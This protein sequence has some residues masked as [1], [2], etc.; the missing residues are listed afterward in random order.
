MIEKRLKLIRNSI[1]LSQKDFGAIMG[2]A[3]TSY[4]NYESGRS[5]IPASL[6]ESLAEKLSINLNWLITGEGSMYRDAKTTAGV[7]VTLGREAE[8]TDSRLDPYKLNRDVP[9]KEKDVYLLPV[10]NILLSAG[11]GENWLSN[12][13]YIDKT[14]PVPRKLAS[15]YSDLIAAIVR[16][17]SM[18]PTIK[19][20][21]P[22]A[23]AKEVKFEGD[24]IYAISRH[25][26]LYIKRLARIGNCMKIISDNPKY[27]IE[28]INPGDEVEEFSIIG[29]VVFWIHVE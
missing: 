3:Q 29:K 12:E 19:N 5:S 25:N 21:E 27:P 11:H 16:G 17:D 22:V 2:I 23:I 28:T 13:E 18:Y 10:T 8:D 7:K 15:K 24:G 4:A 14:L 20:G 6:L 9:S 26:E 1:G